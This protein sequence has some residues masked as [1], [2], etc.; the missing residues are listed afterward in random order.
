MK[1]LTIAVNNPLFIEIQYITLKRYLQTD[2]EFVVFND[3]KTWE[4]VTNFGDVT[5]RQQI[6]D[7]CKK[8]GIK[9]IPL[10]N[11]H[12]KQMQMASHRHCDSLKVL[13]EYI[14]KER[15]EYLVLDSDMC[16]I[17]N[18]D[19]NTYRNFMCAC[20]LQKREQ[21]YIWPNLFYLDTEKM[22]ENE[23][24]IFDL[25]LVPGADTGSA[26]WVWLKSF[27]YT[28]PSLEAVHNAPETLVNDRFY[29]I[30]HLSS[31]N[32]KLFDLPNNMLNPKYRT[33]IEYI[34]KDGRNNMC[35]GNKYYGEIYDNVFY[36]YRGGSNWA[37]FGKEFHYY[38]IKLLHQVITELVES[39]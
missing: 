10:L 15:G 33:L 17:D 19:I 34:Q 36:H 22:T 21:L 38:M 16:L 30:K 24:L 7:V 28:Y 5:M 14:K 13:V 29:F 35:E 4:D 8:N 2:F 12:H 37:N 3:A 39:L 6:E 32:W 18:L 25:S 27:G 9:C 31:G 26:S 20:V 1:V 11:E 23:L